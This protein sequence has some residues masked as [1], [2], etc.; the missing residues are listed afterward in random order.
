MEKTDIYKSKQSLE[1]KI[2]SIEADRDILSLNRDKI[3]E[4]YRSCQANG[5]S[6]AR[7]LRY[8]H[9]LSKLGKFLDK[10]FGKVDK[11]DIEKVL[12]SIENSDYSIQTKLDFRVSIKKF[13]KWLNGGE[14]YPESVK[15]IKTTGKKN[16]KKLPEDLL[17]EQEAKQMIEAA[18]NPRDRALIAVLWD[19]GCRIGELLSMQLK[20]VSFDKEV[21]RITLDGKTGMRRVPLVDSTPYLADWVENHPLKDNPNAPLWIS[22]GTVSHWQPLEYAACR[23]ILRVVAGKAGIK[24]AVN[25]HNFRHSAATHW[26]NYL[27]E[28]QMTQYFGWVQGSD[29]PQVYVH[30]SGRDIDDAIQKAKGLKPREEEEKERALAPKKCPRCGMINKSTGKFCNRCGVV[31]DVKT[32]IEL[33]ERE[34]DAAN[35]IEKALKDPKLKEDMIEA[36]GKVLKNQ[37]S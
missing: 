29:I 5:L 25:P 18:T 14:E 37:K 36:I 31:L 6:P 27:T 11:Q 2:A 21:T 9:D 12:Q 1:R 15:W 32:A 24:K 3:L 26:A 4:F 20:H 13:Y 22:I 34:D 8:L 19:S 17:S 35:W 23:K 10:S 33:Q 28:A 30:L 16:N 7:T